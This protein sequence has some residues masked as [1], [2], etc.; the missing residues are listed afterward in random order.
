MDGTITMKTINRIIIICFIIFFSNGC[1]QAHEQDLAINW[2]EN[3]KA[4]IIDIKNRILEHPNIER[5]QPGKKMK[6]IKNIENFSETDTTFYEEIEQIAIEYGIQIIS[7]YR[8]Y[9][10]PGKK[11]IAVSFAI[12]SVGI[13]GSGH[14][15]SVDYILSE[16]LVD[17]YK[18]ESDNGNQIFPL[19]EKD[20]Y[21]VISS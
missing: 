2:F 14:L 19:S 8:D 12:I 15:V 9:D 21:V 20:W 7:V 16:E 11:L 18:K 4:Q 6:Y 1:G 13:V 3:N 5:I 10:D 17:A